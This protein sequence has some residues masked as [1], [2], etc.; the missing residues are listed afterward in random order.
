MTGV[1]VHEGTPVLVFKRGNASSAPRAI[2]RSLEGNAR[3]QSPEWPHAALLERMKP[4]APRR[5]YQTKVSS[6][7]SYRCVTALKPWSSA[8]QD[9][10]TGLQ[11]AE[12][13]ELRATS[14]RPALR[15]NRG[16]PIPKYDGL[17]LRM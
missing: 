10:A 6:K 1:G 15:G 16:R 7:P 2:S 17:C 9:V 8:P 12:A 14:N 4:D 11:L 13:L 5:I 3:A